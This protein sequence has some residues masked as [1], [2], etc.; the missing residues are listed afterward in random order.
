MCKNVSIINFVRSW[1]KL[2]IR[3]WPGTNL[4]FRL[5]PKYTISELDSNDR[6]NRACS[7]RMTSY[8]N[9]RNRPYSSTPLFAV[10]GSL[11]EVCSNFS[12]SSHSLLKTI[13]RKKRGVILRANLLLHWHKWEYSS[14]SQKINVFDVGIQGFFQQ[15]KI[16]PVRFD[17]MISGEYLVFWAI[18][19]LFVSLTTFKVN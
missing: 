15:Q 17:L 12:L 14:F 1:E 2:K 18:L 3:M 13:I 9:A 8:Q 6:V 7:S 16:T 5:Q 10:S 4:P 19:I 11:P